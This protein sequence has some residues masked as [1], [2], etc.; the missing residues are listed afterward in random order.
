MLSVAPT[1][2]TAG[3]PAPTLRAGVEPVSSAGVHDPGALARQQLPSAVPAPAQVTAYAPY[4]ASAYRPVVR[5]VSSPLAA[6]FIAQEAG[7]GEDELFGIFE[8]SP[9][10]NQSVIVP[11]DSYLSDIRAAR[12]EA[13]AA[14]QEATNAAPS[15]AAKSPASAPS[16]PTTREASE[17]AIAS[18]NSTS[19]LASA[20]PPLTLLVGRQPT[21][22]TA[23]GVG[24]YQLTNTRNAATQKTPKTEPE[25]SGQPIDGSGHLN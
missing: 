11:Q 17:A 2:E 15:N 22:S 5:T 10:K 23:R 6:Q 13:P 16:Q 1:V 20:L 9:A 12:G 19:Q 4:T 7:S 18:R 24:A 21:L 3:V 25:E 8:P 14:P